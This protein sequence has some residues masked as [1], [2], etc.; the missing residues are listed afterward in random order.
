[1]EPMEPPP[2]RHKL[3]ATEEELVQAL[4][5][6]GCVSMVTFLRELCANSETSTGWT[7]ICF[8]VEYGQEDMQR[9][10]H[11]LRANI[12]TMDK[13]GCTLVWIAAA[14][15]QVE[16]VRVLHELGANVETPDND[17]STPVWIA[18]MNGHMDV[19]TVLQDIEWRW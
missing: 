10:L 2:K 13:N 4:G 9:V 11:Q 1:M 19:V 16:V 15:G 6:S 5:H 14:K 8:A 12:E 7:P 18:A 17:G 3:Q